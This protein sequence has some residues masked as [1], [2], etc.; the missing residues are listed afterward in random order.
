MRRRSIG[1]FAA[2]ALAMAVVATTVEAGGWAS[3]ELDEPIGEVRAGRPVDVGFTVRQHG[4]TPIH[5]VS[6]QQV[7]AVF[8]ASS[9]ETG[10]RVERIAVP[11]KPA[12]HFR[13]QVVFPS[14]GRWQAEVTP[15][16]FAG[17][18]LAPVTVLTAAGERNPTSAADEAAI[19]AAPSLESAVRPAANGNRG[20]EVLA[21]LMLASAVVMT[22]A[23]FVAMHGTLSPGRR[24]SAHR[25]R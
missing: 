21:A 1:I 17:T 15:E 8:I 20:K 14:A 22:G 6:G 16:P 9:L 10:E 19:V 7:R 12:G 5:A 24:L 13:V 23:I 18:R 4:V 3:V 11:D 2:V 25:S